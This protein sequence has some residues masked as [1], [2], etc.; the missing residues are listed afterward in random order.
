VTD[1]AAYACEQPKLGFRA[2][3]RLYDRDGG[4]FWRSW[5]ATTGQTR[6]DTAAAIEELLKVV[7]DEQADLETRWR[8]AYLCEQLLGQVMPLERLIAEGDRRLF[9]ARAVGMK[10]ADDLGARWTLL[11]QTNPANDPGLRAVY[12][13]LL[14]DLHWLF[15]KRSL[16]RKLR[17]A[18]GKPLFKR[19]MWTF[20]FCVAP[21]LLIALARAPGWDPMAAVPADFRTSLICGY[22]AVAFGAL[23]AIFSRLTT[24]QARYAAIDYDEAASTFVAQSL[25]L[26]QVVGSVGSLIFFFAIFGGLIGGK[27]FPDAAA[28]LRQGS[29]YSLN[30]EF[31][32]LIVWSFLA[33]F[34][35]RLVP[36][37]LAGT[38]ATAA[39]A[40]RPNA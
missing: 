16:D 40:G 7:K 37:F 21:F 19:T 32:K 33:G 12:A 27:L 39:S 13:T 38:E 6:P 30:E 2:P 17:A 24:F 28:L 1:G 8:D 20:L 35:E 25:N 11:K 9:E 14:D 29:A 4:R 18:I 36:D 22:F 34:S 5:A 31:A 23:G 15:N 26:R 10:S 3:E